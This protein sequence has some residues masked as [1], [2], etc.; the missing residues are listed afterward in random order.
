MTV[1]SHDDPEARKLRVLAIGIGEFGGDGDSEEGPGDR[2]LP[3]AAERADEVAAAL[4][5]FGYQRHVPETGSDLSGNAIEEL[6]RG[7][8]DG[9]G[10]DD[11]LVVHVVSHGY[12]NAAGSLCVLGPDGLEAG[13]NNV[14][15]LVQRVDSD[16]RLP[17]T[18]FLLDLCHAGSVPRAAWQLVS[19]KKRRAWVIAACDANASA[20]A[21]R[22][23]RAAA[24]VLRDG[25]AD[26]GPATAFIP[27]RTVAREIRRE[28]VALAARERGL[29]QEVTSSLV[30]L[31]E[32]VPDLRFFRNP[33]FVTAPIVQARP[34]VDSGVAPFL[35]DV[36]EALDASHFMT[37]ASG[38]G[39]AAAG[40]FSGRDDE[41]QILS[42]WFDGHDSH[43]FRVVTGGPGAGK[44]ALVGILVCAAHPVLH[45]PTRPVWRNVRRTPSVQRQFAAVH[46]RHRTL[47][48]VTG[49]LIAQF[50]LSPD[51]PLLAQ[52]TSLSSEVPIVVI[53]ALDEA[54]DPAA[55]VSSLLLPL[56]TAVRADRQPI[57]RLLVAMRPWEEFAELTAAAG[58]GLIDLDTVP[59]RQLKTDLNQ[60]VDRL[61]YAF[62]PYDEVPFAGARATFAAGVAEVLTT[63]DRPTGAFLVAGMYAHHLVTA[64]KPV[65]ETEKAWE[66]AR[67]V[68][69][70]LEDLLELDLSTRTETPWLRPILAALAHAR[71][72]GMPAVLAGAAARGLVPGVPGPTRD[73]IDEVV[74]SAGRFYLRQSTDVDGT[75]L[76]RL[77][78]QGLA[79]HLK[80]RP[81]AG[82]GDFSGVPRKMFAA[83]LDHL[84]PG[85][86]GVRRWDLAEPYLLRHAVD[87]ARDAGAVDEMVEDAE[88]LVHAGPGDAPWIE[89]RIGAPIVPVGDERR[90]QFAISASI[91][92]DQRAAE[93]FFRRPG[94]QGLAWSP[95]WSTSWRLRAPGTAAVN[96]TVVVS[97]AAVGDDGII[98]VAFEG[99]VDVLSA[100][101]VRLATLSS[102][103]RPS[104]MV[105]GNVAGRPVLATFGDGDARLWD[106]RNGRQVAGLPM[107]DSDHDW[108]RASVL[109]GFPIDVL[110][111]DPPGEDRAIV[112]GVLVSVWFT[113]E[114]GLR[115][116]VDL[117][118]GSG[119]VRCFSLGGVPHAVRWDSA[120]H[121]VTV[122]NLA[123]ESVVR[124]IVMPRPCVDVMPA[125]EGDLVVRTGEAVTYL[126]A[127]PPPA[128]ARRPAAVPSPRT[129]R[130]STLD[131]RIKQVIEEFAASDEVRRLL[132]PDAV[133]G[134]A[135][136][137]RW[138]SFHLGLLRLPPNLSAEWR[139]R[140]SLIT[141]PQGWFTPDE[142]WTRLP[143]ERGGNTILVPAFHDV[144]GVVASGDVPPSEKV[145]VVVRDPARPSRPWPRSA[146]RDYPEIGVVAD[147]MLW[148]ASADRTAM[149]AT[150]QALA[151]A[152]DAQDWFTKLLADRIADF[153]RANGGE[154]LVYQS[155]RV[156]EALRSIVH[157]P[158]PA[159]GSWI[160]TRRRLPMSLVQL[161][162]E[163]HAPDLT[164]SEP[165]TTEM[166]RDVRARGMTDFQQDIA[167]AVTEPGDIGRVLDVLRPAL[168]GPAGGAHRWGRVIYGRDS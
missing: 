87:L 116:R 66:I 125:G 71:G 97:A 43:R 168:L 3:F 49:S 163:R 46:V 64:Y 133:A 128:A 45:V 61:L 65:A 104:R 89:E 25:V 110:L 57:C 84:D 148:L 11:L 2:S 32:D 105:F 159:R 17:R 35:A 82:P 162:A 90:T 101:G 67:R 167:V 113:P 103:W 60:Y 99:Q 53:D 100:S 18:L 107:P 33:R 106:Y 111:P 83:M 39:G 121:D 5:G 96:E 94:G 26:I 140:L 1:A 88:F 146:V 119:F 141:M 145:Q 160:D 91:A 68:P 44:S 120:G 122:W 20:F 164:V 47:A 135:P 12:L 161:L 123:S 48:E 42:D 40:C 165:R 50:G 58:D 98:A 149:L 80:A 14:D 114:G 56:A 55:L 156:A 155:A 52:M 152:T 131:D 136:A 23:S 115:T 74:G 78:H 151:P 72:E 134:S 126:R 73:E 30:D 28:V 34:R 76:Y 27:L 142:G 112:G 92:G 13:F 21:G 9:L 62:P 150:G 7:A 51:E 19:L 6:I 117:A 41:L 118:E 95:I 31:A 59:Q 127:E 86:W 36:D 10:A 54:S 157:T 22:F 4:S 154:L 29:S 8:F 24:S 132:G 37:R 81:V 102:G 143:S 137:E 158:A 147:Q 124:R 166:Y 15:S 69:R 77:F 63:G 70:S 153:N 108:I 130:F 144:P 129:A 75:S 38:F 79:D 16:A 139:S 93:R 138:L 85:G 109:W